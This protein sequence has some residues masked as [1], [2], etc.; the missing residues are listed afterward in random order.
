MT[1]TLAKLLRL[2]V[3]LLAC[4][5]P[6]WAAALDQPAGEVV[7]TISGKVG[8]PNAGRRAVFDMAMLEKLP[9]HSFSTNTPWHAGPTRFTGPLLRDVLAAAGANGSKLV[10]VA[11]NDYKTD[12]PFTDAARYDVIVAAQR[13]AHAGAREGAAVH[14]LPVR[15]QGRAQGRNLL[16]PFGLAVAP[17]AGAVTRPNAPTTTGPHPPVPAPFAC[18]AANVSCAC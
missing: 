13:Q 12:I 3:L 1:L 11:L 7:L 6:G 15:Q 16:Q 10:A 8:Q 4:L 9:Q 18:R 14:R 5:T 17:V 2:S